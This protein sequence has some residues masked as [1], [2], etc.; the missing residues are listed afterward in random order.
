MVN[1]N[2]RSIE[3][4]EQKLPTLPREEAHRIRRASRAYADTLLPTAMAG[5]AEALVCEDWDVRW[6]AIDRVLK[7]TMAGVPNEV[8]DPES[9][10]VDGS[11][12]AKDA[13]KTLEEETENGTGLPE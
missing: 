3:P 13:L 11:V 6:K 5:L 8:A 4:V 1:P 12:T 10:V 7:M 2:E 9:A